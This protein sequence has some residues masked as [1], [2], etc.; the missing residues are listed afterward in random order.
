MQLQ[1]HAHPE[2]RQ[3]SLERMAIQYSLA[4]LATFPFVGEGIRRGTLALHGAWFSIAVGELHWLDWS[5]GVF[6]P[7]E[8]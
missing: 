4:N 8:P 6:E 3:Q 1:A 2:F 5:T 7:A